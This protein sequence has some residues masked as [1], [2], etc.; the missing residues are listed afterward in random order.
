MIDDIVQGSYVPL[1]DEDTPVFIASGRNTNAIPGRVI[2][3][4]SDRSYLVET[5]TGM[6][7]RNRSYLNIRTDEQI[8]APAT[9]GNVPPRTPIAT[10]LRTGTVIKP[11][12]KLTF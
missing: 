11:P 3:C 6:S 1:L 5:P 12:N 2:E 4:A 9:Q 7:R 8:D 10:R